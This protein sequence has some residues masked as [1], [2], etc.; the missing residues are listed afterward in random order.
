MNSNNLA[1]SN[2]GENRESLIQNTKRKTGESKNL[3]QLHSDNDL[4]F[5][6]KLPCISILFPVAILSDIVC[7]RK[8]VFSFSVSPSS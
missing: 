8:N 2:M 7:L 3:K 4:I 1:D 6:G 5:I